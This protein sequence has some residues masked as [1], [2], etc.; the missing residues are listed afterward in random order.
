MQL[1]WLATGLALSAPKPD[2]QLLPDRQ[3]TAEAAAEWREAR[4]A[5]E[6]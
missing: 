4:D 2:A 1:E 6:R 5:A 3:A